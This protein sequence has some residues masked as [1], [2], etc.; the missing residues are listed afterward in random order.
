MP[1]QPIRHKSLINSQHPDRFWRLSNQK[2]ESERLLTETSAD[3]TQSS[4]FCIPPCQDMGELKRV[5]LCF[6]RDLTEVY[7]V[8]VCHLRKRPGLEHLISRFACLWTRIS[9]KLSVPQYGIT[10]YR[11]Q[12]F[13]LCLL[14]KTPSWYD[15]PF[16]RYGYFLTECPIYILGVN[17]L[18]F[19]K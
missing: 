6:A 14:V 5:L 18:H 8:K 9:P 7:A 4:L 15:H 12:I 10:T 17:G 13:I 2:P 19:P 1:S 3:P 11:D 16:L